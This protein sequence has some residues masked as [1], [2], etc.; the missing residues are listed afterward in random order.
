M[1]IAER[2]CAVHE[3]TLQGILKVRKKE[4][5]QFLD[6]RYREY[7]RSSLCAEDPVFFV[8]R[9][10]T[11]RDVEIAGLIA[12]SLAY[13][14]IRLIKNSIFEI[15]ASVGSSLSG[16]LTSFHPEEWKRSFAG[17]RHRFNNGEDIAN[18]LFFM[19]QMIERSGSIENYF[20]EGYEPKN[21]L[22][23]ALVSFSE[24]SLCLERVKES[25]KTGRGKSGGV[26]F[27][28]PSPRDGSTC[29]RLN[30][31]LRWMVRK[32][33]I[34]RGVW[35]AL[36]PSELIVPVDTHIARA[37]R[38]LGFTRRKNPSW[39]MAC[40]ITAA[41]REFDPIDPVKYDF[42]LCHYRWESNKDRK[43]D[44]QSAR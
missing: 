23:G 25:K 10:S 19:K 32:D 38:R 40:E 14:R 37:S 11:K 30:L 29:K 2:H 26:E 35:T 43:R 36:S 18:L 42:S 31:Y 22:R 41:L 27:F 34:D 20:M 4:L 5:K 9:Y 13:G 12:S 21:G 44:D 8:H 16:F 7:N 6:A 33:N 28:F 3:D 1:R 15:L 17:F 24:R 39:A